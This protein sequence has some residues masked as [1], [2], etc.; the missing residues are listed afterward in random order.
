MG[1]RLRQIIQQLLLIF[2]TL[3]GKICIGYISKIDSNY[4]KQIIL[5]MI[6]IEEKKGRDYVAVKK[7]SAL[8]N[9]IT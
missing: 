8:L 2:Y 1:K 3:K 6:S 7:L 4:G 9:E 5:L